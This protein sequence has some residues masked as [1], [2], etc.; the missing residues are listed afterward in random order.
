MRSSRA[1]RSIIFSIW[2]CR[3]KISRQ[4]Q[5]KP[6]SLRHISPVSNQYHNARLKH[7][8]VRPRL[9]RFWRAATTTTEDQSWKMTVG[10]DS[11]IDLGIATPMRNKIHWGFKKATTSFEFGR[12][13][14]LYRT[15]REPSR[16]ARDLFQGLLESKSSGRC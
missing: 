1:I 14:S 8:S 16:E 7:G 15:S 12:K 4:Y 6:D 3:R 11:Q 2:Y 5:I 9:I 13:R 10:Q